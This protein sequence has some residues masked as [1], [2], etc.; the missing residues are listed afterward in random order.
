MVEGCDTNNYEKVLP[1]TGGEEM[2]WR[3]Q[4]KTVASN[5]HNLIVERTASGITIFKKQR[6][7]FGDLPTKKPK[8]LLY[9]PEYSSGNGTTVLKQIFGKKVFDNPKPVQ[10]LKDFISLSTQQDDIILV[11]CHN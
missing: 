3:W 9:K 4:R 1:I 11:V 8:S 2:S 7:G 6:P 10:L 5:T